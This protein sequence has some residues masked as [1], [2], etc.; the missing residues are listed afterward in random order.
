MP[1]TSRIAQQ[2]EVRLV[3]DQKVALLKRRQRCNSDLEVHTGLEVGQ[4][5]Q[6]VQDIAVA[7]KRALIR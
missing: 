4:K 1:S 7:L 6:A 2:E 3:K 5:H